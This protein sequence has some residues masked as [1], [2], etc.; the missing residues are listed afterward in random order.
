[1]HRLTVSL[2]RASVHVSCNSA[3]CLRAWSASLLAF[4]ARAL[5][6]S[7]CSHQHVNQHASSAPCQRLY[8]L[9]HVTISNSQPVCRH[10][11]LNAAGVDL[12]ATGVDLARVPIKGR[13]SSLRPHQHS[14]MCSAHKHTGTATART[15]CC[16]VAI[17]PSSWPLLCALPRR[18]FSSC[19]WRS[20]S[21]APAWAPTSLAC[22]CAISTCCLATCC[23]AYSPWSACAPCSFS[24]CRVLLSGH[25]SARCAEPPLRQMVSVCKLVADEGAGRGK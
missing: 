14:G 25:C 12:A 21:R 1:M 18:A 4:A 13:H 11:D 7:T 10:R 5:P 2:T 24:W 20:A 19:R 23:L 8:C 6:E 9:Q 3:R 22:S 16:S 15:S 17:M